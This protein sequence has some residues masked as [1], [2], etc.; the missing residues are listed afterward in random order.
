MTVRAGYSV[1]YNA[2]VYNQFASSLASQ[3]PWAQAQTRQSTGAQLLTLQDGFPATSPN[4]LR[5]TIAIDPDYTLAYAQLWNLSVETPLFRN[6]PFAVTYTG[7]KGTH[8]DMLLGFSGS[9]N[10]NPLV[11]AQ[12]SAIQDAQGFTYNT[13]GANS[14]FHALQMRIQGRAS[15][16][17][18][19]GA[20]Y[21]LGKS[22]DNASSIGGGQQVIAQNIQDLRAERGLSS[23]DVRHQFRTNYSYDLPFGE[24]RRFARAG[25]AATLLGD[26][27]LTSTLNLRSGSP[28]TA[29]VFD[30]ACQILPGVYSERADQIGNPSL[31]ASQR[32]AQQFFNTAAFSV[33]SGSCIGGAA[34]NTITGPG[35]FTMNL[36]LAKNIRLGRDGQRRMEIRWEV[37]NLTNT[38][39]FTGL[40]TVVNSSTF[41][42]VTGA[43]GMRTMTIRTRVNF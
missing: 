15:R 37:N 1:M 4:T 34:R 23:F 11:S 39:N 21:T 6:A 13:S 7:T 30:S 14:I 35:S 10:L 19:F 43:A 12:S 31:P 8:L 24:R 17:M 28:F 36:Q 41:G 40:S 2:S 9:N 18:R 29:R 25:W 33:P 16:A 32:T 22:V 5:N 3:P 27:S 26:W 20:A 42:R 38:P